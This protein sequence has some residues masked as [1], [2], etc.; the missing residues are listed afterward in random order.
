MFDTEID[1]IKEEC[2]NS[3]KQIQA[4]AQVIDASIIKNYKLWPTNYIAYDILNKTKVYSH[5]YTADEKI[6]FGRRLEMRIDAENPI[7]LQDY[8]TCMR[9]RSLIN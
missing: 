9:I 1:K 6:A 7:A 8:Y 5:L 4:L 3:N 2:S